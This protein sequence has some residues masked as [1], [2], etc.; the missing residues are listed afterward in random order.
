MKKALRRRHDAPRSVRIRGSD[1]SVIVAGGDITING[2]KVKSKDLA[3][4]ED[5]E[6]WLRRNYP[7]KPDSHTK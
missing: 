1:T 4:P 7:Y 2:K 6:N 5:Y 3:N